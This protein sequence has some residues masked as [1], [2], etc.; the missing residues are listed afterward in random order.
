M[1][2]LNSVA[3]LRRLISGITEKMLI[4]QLRELEADEIIGRNIFDEVP[5]RVEYFMTPY[6]RT[7]EPALQILCHWGE[8]H[9][10]YTQAE[11]NKALQQEISTESLMLDHNGSGDRTFDQR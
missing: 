4:Q 5:P 1:E 10:Q 3:E 11:E 7:L 8:A 2:A 6:G 9:L